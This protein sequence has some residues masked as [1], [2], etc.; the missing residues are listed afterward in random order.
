[1]TAPLEDLCEV[2]VTAPDGAWLEDLCR[3]LVTNRLAA[4]AHVIHNVRSIY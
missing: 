1:M 4:S 2:I 3:Q